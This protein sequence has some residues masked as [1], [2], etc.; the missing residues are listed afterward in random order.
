MTYKELEAQLDKANE[1]D[2][3]GNYD[4]AQRLAIE[5]ITTL[6]TTDS[7]PLVEGRDRGL[8]RANAFLIIASIERQLG[9]FDTSLSQAQQA[10][11]LAV[12]YNL[13]KIKPKAWNTIGNVY[14]NLSSYD[15]A[16]EYYTNALAALEELGEISGVA[17]VTGCIGG[18]YLELGSYDKALEYFNKAGSVYEELGDRY[19][20]AHAW[21]NIGQLYQRIG[22][23]DKSLEYLTMSLAVN[24]QLGLKS[25]IASNNLILGN[26]NIHLGSYE[27]ALEHFLTSLS[28]NQE[29]GAKSGIASATTNIGIVYYNLL[30][31]EK[32]REYFIK[33]LPLHEEIGSKTH[34][35]MVKGN[36]GNTYSSLQDYSRCL[37]WKKEALEIA[38]EIG[39]RAQIAH[40]RYG[41]GSALLGLEQ[42]EES[43]E[44]YLSALKIQ[45]DE[46]HS[47]LHVASYLFSIG[48]LLVQSGKLNEGLEKL[49]EGLA[50]AEQLGEKSS[51]MYIH[52]ELSKAFD[53]KGDVAKAFIHFKKFYDLEKEVQSDEAKQ[54]S[55]RLEYRRKIEESERDRQIKLARFQEQE[56]ILHNI[57]P[58]QI[59]ERM[60]AGEKMIAESH[61]HVSVFFSDIVG[62]TKL[63][64]RVSAKELVGMLNGIFTQFDQL[65]RRHGLE[66]IKTIG[67]AYMAVAGAPITQENH[68]ERAAM[69]ALDVADLMKNYQSN[70]GDNITIRIGLHSGSVVAGIIGENKFAYDLWGDAVNTASRMESHGEPGR[71]H[72]SEEFAFHLQNRLDKTGDDLGGIVFV[73]RDEIEI[74]GKGRM[75]TY[76]LEQV[77]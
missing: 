72:V 13:L 69:F 34:V 58:E 66:K 36:I 23:Y 29:I 41:I 64:Q 44:Y 42:Y 18:V 61:E 46:L 11:A 22:T 50:L 32:A 63:S 37:V 70:S 71:I 54:E 53:I 40:C 75:K 62:F 45:R 68:A 12:E 6:D 52:L 3:T 15:K 9:N 73:E 21:G 48:S 33:S 19:N 4:E 2:N 7:F 49:E 60:V 25:R 47:H 43:L 30:A 56:K 28:I 5:V 77:K 10:L 55:E 26:V 27:K 20:L 14:L 24:E 31:Y 67:D 74:K 16:L 8:L 59:A 1:H 35:A 39:D 76:F 17:G 51:L 57:L 38:E 65:A